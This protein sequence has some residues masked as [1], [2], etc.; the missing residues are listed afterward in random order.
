MFLLSI[1][2][3]YEYT[4]DYVAHV[5]SFKYGNMSTKVLAVVM[6]KYATTTE[7]PH[8]NIITLLPN[9]NYQV[10]A[11]VKPSQANAALMIM[12]AFITLTMQYFLMS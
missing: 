6:A 11:K 4:H 1:Y 8:R 5:P 12:R 7:H 9:L 2:I 10:K 3:T